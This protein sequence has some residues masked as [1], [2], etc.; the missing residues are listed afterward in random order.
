MGQKLVVGGAIVAVVG[1]FLPWFTVDALGTTAS[2]NG[3][4]RDGIFTFVFALI[5]VGLILYQGPGRWKTG[6]LAG[7][8]ILGALIALVGSA[9]I[10][11]PWLGTEQPS[12]AEQALINIGS[13][14]YLTAFSGYIIIGGMA[15]D[16]FV[17]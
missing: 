8:L 16:R 3:I 9:Y 6:V 17:D 12:E 15:Y 13:G 7:C 1:A 5:A 2:V 14:L 11:D 4:E 10:Y